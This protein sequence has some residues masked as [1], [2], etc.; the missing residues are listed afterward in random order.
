MIFGDTIAAI[1]TAPGRSGVAIIRVSGPDAKKVALQLTK[2]EPLCGR[3]SL[4]HIYEPKVEEKESQREF[5]DEALTLFFQAPK[6]YTGEDV[7]EIQ[8]HGGSVTPHRILEACFAAG[9][10]LARRG[11]FTQRAY[12]NGKMSYEQSAALLDLINAKTTRAADSALEGLSGKRHRQCHALYERTLQLS[13]RL[14]H[15][16]DIEENELPPDFIPQ[17]VDETTQIKNELLNL[18]RHLREGKIL[19][20]GALVVLA[21]PPNVG[22]SS[23]LNALLEE[24]RAIVSE[25]PGTTRDT[26]EE[27]MDVEG[28]PLRLVDTAGIRVT[29]DEIEDEG[30]RRSQELIKKAMIVLWLGETPAPSEIAPSQLIVVHAKCDLGHGTGLNVSAKTGEG[31]T[32]LKHTLVEKLQQLTA[33]E[34]ENDEDSSTES[35]AFQQALLSLQN[36]NLI[37]VD[38]VLLANALRSAAECLGAQ[39]GATYS[40]DMLNNLFSRFCVGK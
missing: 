28:W 14:E 37:E 26:I 24:H 40:S 33:I 25:R 5:I 17:I 4:A 6:S 19:R 12:L 22:K 30:V 13:T 38:L 7:F 29:S 20:T 36:V 21:G 31:L 23:L 11:E 1:A 2:K 3:A 16:L 9:A 8:C 32:E 35:A 39:I 10:R 27:W 34:G 18:L 15:I